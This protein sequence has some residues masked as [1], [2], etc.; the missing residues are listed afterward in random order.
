MSGLLDKLKLKGNSTK[1]SIEAV[2]LE[3][4]LM[5]EIK[6]SSAKFL[7]DS[8]IEPAPEAATRSR[9]SRRKKISS[10]KVVSKK[11]SSTTD[12]SNEQRRMTNEYQDR[13][14]QALLKR[15]KR[16][17]DKS[18]NNL[19]GKKGQFS[20][21]VSKRQ[22]DAITSPEVV[23]RKLRPVILGS[24]DFDPCFGNAGREEYYPGKLLRLK[25]AVRR[26]KVDRQIKPTIPDTSFPMPALASML[27]EHASSKEEFLNSLAPSNISVYQDA[28]SAFGITL[29]QNVSNSETVYTLLK[30]LA[31]SVKYS[32]SRLDESSSRSLDGEAGLVEEKDKKI[33]LYYSGFKKSKDSY[34]HIALADQ[35]D[36]EVAVKCLT[37]I[38]AK[39]VVHSYNIMKQKIERYKPDV[40]LQVMTDK[41]ILSNPPFMSDRAHR[42]ANGVLFKTVVGKD[43]T[44]KITYNYPLESTQVLCKNTD[45]RSAHQFVEDLYTEST[46]MY[47]TSTSGLLSSPYEAMA[48]SFTTANGELLDL[49]KSDGLNF[50]SATYIGLFNNILSSITT[51][52]AESM[53]NVNSA[54]ECHILRAAGTDNSLWGDFL[55]YLAFRDERRLGFSGDYLLPDGPS[56]CI[57]NN[58]LLKSKAG[59]YTTGKAT[60]GFSLEPQSV[61]LSPGVDGQ[62][63]FTAPDVS[64]TAELETEPSQFEQGT[65]E[66]SFGVSFDDVCASFAEK[67]TKHFAS[68]GESSS[69]FTVDKSIATTNTMIKSCLTNIE[70]DLSLLDYILSYNDILDSAI[71]NGDDDIDTIFIGSSQSQ[72]TLFSQIPRRNVFLAFSLLCCK[73]TRL[74]LESRASISA[75]SPV[76]GDSLVIKS[77][78][79]K[80][81]KKG[82][83]GA[84]FG[85]A[86]SIAPSLSVGLSNAAILS[87]IS[88]Q[89]GLQFSADFS[90][91]L[92]DI[93]TYL[94]EPES[95]FSSIIDSYPVIAAVGAALVEEEEFLTSASES[96]LTYFQTVNSNFSKVRSSINTLH[97]GQSLKEVIALGLVPSLDLSKLLASYSMSLND[98]CMVYDG[99]KLRD[100][101]IGR[102][103]LNLL[104][105]TL[106]NNSYQSKK[107]IFAIAIPTGL[108]ERV[109]DS[110]TQIEEIR[111][112]SKS[113]QPDIFSLSVQKID[114]VN[115]E[116]EYEDV[117]FEFSRSLFVIGANINLAGKS[118]MFAVVD[119]NLNFK[120]STTDDLVNN[121]TFT[122]PVIWNHWQD[123]VLKQYLDLQLDVDISERAFPSSPIQMKQYI[124]DNVDVSSI[125]YINKGSSEFLSASNLAFDPLK[126]NLDSL[127]F[128][129]KSTG[130][131]DLRAPKNDEY[132]FSSFEYV[133]AYGS[134]FVPEVELKRMAAGLKFERILCVS[135]SDDDFKIISPNVGESARSINAETSAMLAGQKSVSIGAETSQGV[136]LNTYR[137]SLVIDNGAQK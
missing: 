7:E 16:S 108:L 92:S 126:R 135:F 122:Y 35:Q 114:Q 39:E 110:P 137:F 8:D 14:K 60:K 24:F 125:S 105:Q 98:S 9:K 86:S 66:S 76:T 62:T 45:S 97:N 119:K 1:K 18:T 109:S 81:T 56:S 63:T 101:T 57:R 53:D 88:P 31:Y 59:K 80:V 103:G 83:A 33:E 133:N 22:Q 36:I 123:A 128:Y 134:I 50:G 34:A 61:T 118:P 2:S 28:L 41:N 112:N 69:E 32:T 78:K 72:K 10:N 89:V 82:S 74:L 136:D 64:T 121:K 3:V 130:V 54:L 87:S 70:A 38:L 40:I 58:W 30:E 15:Q 115:P 46:E 13:N 29:S 75:T 99:V 84:A 6:A 132:A 129:N 124:S 71:P 94:N 127:S 19:V 67:L 12:I 107:K 96:F 113:S 68:S 79:P 43:F 91:A 25:R 117:T 27:A 52:V 106:S 77:S 26:I 73:M 4:L 47:R 51:V 85:A 5:E 55:I 49:V 111:K 65:L 100:N 104:R 11:S 95:D 37:S 116:I 131:L 17:I 48:D 20:G 21:R 90:S 23:A 93:T 120:E 44:S 42:S 102:Y